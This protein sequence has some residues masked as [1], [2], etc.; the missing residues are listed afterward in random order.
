M[1]F[2]RSTKWMKKRANVLRRDSYECRECKRYGKVTEANVVHHV[3][4]LD[5]HP[6]LRLVSN[7]L[8]SV[9]GSC[10]NTFHDRY[11][12]ELTVKGMEW[13][14]RIKKLIKI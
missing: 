7:N 11:T 4:P 8:L 3:N 10:H 5:T 2:Y 9:C 1:S 14:E 6:D 13:V 12:N